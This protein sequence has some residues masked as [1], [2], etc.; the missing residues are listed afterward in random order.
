M[1]KFCPQG[2]SAHSCACHRKS[3]HC[4]APAEP[5]RTF[6]GSVP[7][8]PGTWNGGQTEG[9]NHAH[10]SCTWAWTTCAYRALLISSA[11]PS[12]LNISP[13]SLPGT[14]PLI[15]GQK[16]PQFWTLPYF[17]LV[18]PPFKTSMEHGL[19][20]NLDL[21]LPFLSLYFS[22]IATGACSFQVPQ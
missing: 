19:R 14:S 20:F 9:T 8:P 18:T 2:L 21:S 1:Y 11:C 5:T 17:T 13:K 15:N 3:G 10:V 16:F 4:L 22:G 6:R 12:K 7:P